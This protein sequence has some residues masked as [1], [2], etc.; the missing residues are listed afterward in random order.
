MRQCS[1]CGRPEGQGRPT[2]FYCGGQVVELGGHHLPLK[3]PRCSAS[4][5]AQILDGV[6]LDIC[7]DCGGAWYDREELEQRLTQAS[8]ESEDS[9]DGDSK[10]DWQRSDQIYLS[11][12]KCSKPMNRMNFGRG[13]GII[14]DMCGP[15]GL[16][17]DSGEFEAISAYQGS[18]DAEIDRKL[19]QRR[20]DVRDAQQK[21]DRARERQKEISRRRGRWLSG[22]WGGFV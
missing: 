1:K 9:E 3:C 10:P 8:S 22:R 21:R 14:I 19:H 17:L 5:E 16:F 13:S 6:E 2:C 12:P 4:L 20:Q 15:H 11:C 18:G 7:M